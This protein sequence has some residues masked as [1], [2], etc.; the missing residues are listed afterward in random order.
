M[1]RSL[2]VGRAKTAGE[3]SRNSPLRPKIA[4]EFFGEVLGRGE[5]ENIPVD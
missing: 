5:S 1:K 2:V 3:A 4:L